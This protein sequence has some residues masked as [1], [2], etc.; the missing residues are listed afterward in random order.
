MLHEVGPR[1]SSCRGA[2]ENVHQYEQEMKPPG[3]KGRAGKG[4]SDIGVSIK[5]RHDATRQPKVSLQSTNR[6]APSVLSTSE[7]VPRIMSSTASFDR[8]RT[9]LLGPKP[10]TSQKSNSIVENRSTTVKHDKARPRGVSWQTSF[11]SRRGGDKKK[12]I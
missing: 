3:E 1:P 6:T 7:Q 9:N 8:E 10:C 11:R 12:L 5:K 2:P 4:S